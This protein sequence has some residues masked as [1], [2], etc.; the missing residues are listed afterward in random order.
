MK[1]NYLWVAL[2]VVTLLSCDNQVEQS[3]NQ[4]A[5]VADNITATAKTVDYNPN[6]NAYFGDLHIHSSWSF[7]AFIY[8]VRTT[9]EDAYRFGKGEMIQHPVAGDIQ[10]RRPL[11]FMAVTDHAEYMGVMMQMLDKDSPLAKLEFAKRIRSEDRA[12]SL[13]AFGEVG[14]S[15][16]RNEPMTD[17]IEKDVI[18]DTWQKQ[19][20][21]ANRFNEPGVFTTFPAYEWTSSPSRGSGAPENMYAANMHRNVI[22]KGDKISTIPFSSFDSQDPEQ[23]WKWMEKEKAKGIDLIAIPHNSNMSDGLMYDKKTYDGRPI[24]K[25][26]AQLR[27]DNEPI[28]EVVQIKGQSMSHPLLNPNDEFA[29]YELYAYTFAVGLPP[30]SKPQG[31]YVREAFEQGLSHKKELGVNPYEFGIIGSSDGHNSGG[32]VEEDGYFGKLGVVDGS[33]QVRLQAG[34]RGSRFL[35]SRYM[36]AAGLAGVWAEENTR[37][38]IYSSLKRKETFATS[39]PRIAVRFF[40]GTDFA[41]TDLSDQSW[42]D[43]AYDSGVPMGSKL[44]SK[45]ESPDFIVW[46]SKDADGAN[47]DRI[48]IIKQWIDKAGKT[49]E[50]IYNAAWSDKR[51]KDANGNIP[52]V[53]NTVD[54]PDASYTNTIGDATLS[55][56]WNDP[57]FD[58]AQ[59]A[60]YLVRVLEI[61][62]PRWTT[63]DAKALGIIIPDDLDATTQERAWSSPIWYEPSK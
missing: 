25:A 26:Y 24:D 43:K 17:L 63:Y 35:R 3:K 38:S 40:M 21:I 27:I 23:L 59:S 16:A 45:T 12:E 9:P 2:V 57:D 60:L 47:L 61:P 19:I 62:T 22:Y 18:S 10:N 54:V 42:L 39:G 13:A 20:E 28:N 15:L 46:A 53:G 31:S 4:S 56:V 8:N 30:A 55:A 34:E 29:D 44:E 14:Q 32:P 37:S 6:R 33:P 5:D 11:D 50:K 52:A 1:T 49:H 36:S 41:G 58:A 51:V 7:D 48:Q